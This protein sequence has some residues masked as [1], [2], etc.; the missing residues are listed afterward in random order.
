LTVFFGEDEN[1]LEQV[2]KYYKDTRCLIDDD[3]PPGVDNPN[4]DESDD[5]SK[6]NDDSKN[7]KEDYNDDVREENKEKGQSEDD[8]NEDKN[9][10]QAKEKEKHG[11]EI[12]DVVNDNI[13]TKVGK[14]NNSIT[15]KDHENNDRSIACVKQT[16]Q[17]GE[18]TP[19]KNAQCAMSKMFESIDRSM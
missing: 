19:K 5:D 1:F 13:E 2:K 14:D 15:K 8:S 10:E 11:K 18:G 6:E 16:Q 3:V 12:T 9:K 7:E 4:E 17:H